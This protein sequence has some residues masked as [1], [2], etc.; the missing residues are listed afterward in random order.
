[1]SWSQNLED[2]ITNNVIGK[3]ASNAFLETTTISQP[4]E[5]VPEDKCS[6]QF[7]NWYEVVK[8]GGKR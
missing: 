8:A 7:L 6:K 2:L 5:H 3:L 1:M 4:I